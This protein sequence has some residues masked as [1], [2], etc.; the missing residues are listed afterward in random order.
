M[1][2]L[3]SSSEKAKRTTKSRA[4]FIRRE[5]WLYNVAENTEFRNM[6]HTLESRYAIPSREYFSETVVP[7]TYDDIKDSM[8]VLQI[9]VAVYLKVYSSC[10]CTRILTFEC[11]STGLEKV[12]IIV[13][14]IT[15]VI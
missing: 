10:F 2:K 8:R 4:D 5:P 9:N 7:Q 13:D 11:S 14:S 15:N 1:Y 3:P 12:Y 6:P